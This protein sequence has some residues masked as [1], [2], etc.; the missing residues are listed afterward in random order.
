MI[1]PFITDEQVAD[2]MGT[3][4]KWDA[5]G[6]ATSALYYRHALKCIEQVM[7]KDVAGHV[8]LLAGCC[9]DGMSQASV[10]LTQFNTKGVDAD[11]LVALAKKEQSGGTHGN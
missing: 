3:P 8:H 10:H 7:G 2:L 9:S 6:P 5:W 1:L 11:G 4:P